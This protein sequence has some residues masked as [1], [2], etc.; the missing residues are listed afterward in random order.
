MCTDQ[1]PGLQMPDGAASSVTDE[2]QP[3]T[4]VKIAAAAK[5]L[6]LTT[7]QLLYRETTGVLLPAFRSAAGARYYDPT[8]LADGVAGSRRLVKIGEAAAMLGIT[9]KQLLHRETTGAIKP[10]F[11]TGGGTR[12]YD[13]DNLSGAPAI[14]G[15]PV[16]FRE[17]AAI[18]SVT[19]GELLHR[20]SIGDLLPLCKTEDGTRYYDRA[21]LESRT[22]LIKIGGAAK[23]IGATHNRMRY[24][25]KSAQLLPAVKSAGGTRYYRR[26]EALKFR[27]IYDLSARRR[28]PHPPDTSSNV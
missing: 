10:A 23:I 11:K 13:P 4:L 7:R 5:I 24:W 3:K 18:L 6:G 27:R 17:A 12:Y 9:T 2:P 19:T 16:G 14:P 26:D 25:E 20:E 22:T 28:R 21:E 1:I 8:S 15:P